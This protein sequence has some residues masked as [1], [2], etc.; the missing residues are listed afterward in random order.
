MRQK[1][2]FVK[3]WFRDVAANGG[4]E[5]PVR[6]RVVKDTLT[7]RLMSPDEFMKYVNDHLLPNGFL[8]GEPVDPA[9]G[10]T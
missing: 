1:Q 10:A 3:S 7:G 8:P 6:L 9:Q 5:Y 4:H 2:R